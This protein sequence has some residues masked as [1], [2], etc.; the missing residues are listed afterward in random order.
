MPKTK[1]TIK[2]PKHAI[3]VLDDWSLNT[4]STQNVGDHVGAII[5]FQ[6]FDDEEV[7][8]KVASSFI[9]LEQ[10]QLNLDREIGKNSFEATKNEARNAWEKE[11]SRIKIYDDNLDNIKTFYSCLYRLVSVMCPIFRIQNDLGH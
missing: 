7:E 5:G 8:V 3:E 2:M 10:A 6:T 11:L 4:N 1:I 9:S